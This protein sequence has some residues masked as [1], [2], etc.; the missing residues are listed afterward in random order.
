MEVPMG[1]TCA[2]STDEQTSI[3]DLREDDGETEVGERKELGR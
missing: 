1:L 3:D 2:E